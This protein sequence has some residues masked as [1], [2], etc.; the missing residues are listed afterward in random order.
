MPI[1][2]KIQKII[3]GRVPRDWQNIPVQKI[4]RTLKDM[5]YPIGLV[6]TEKKVLVSFYLNKSTVRFFKKEADR[7]HAKYQRMMRAV[8]E[9]YMHHHDNRIPQTYI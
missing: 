1:S 7:H 5:P 4:D 3:A 6:P 8:L 9:R 2:I